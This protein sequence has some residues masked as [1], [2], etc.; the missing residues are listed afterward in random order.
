MSTIIKNL[1]IF[2]FS[3]GFLNDNL[4]ILQSTLNNHCKINILL[5]LLLV[6]SSSSLYQ[7]NRFE[8]IIVD[9]C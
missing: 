8:P 7:I 4:E 1:L 2:P 3:K 6:P 5:H 9:F